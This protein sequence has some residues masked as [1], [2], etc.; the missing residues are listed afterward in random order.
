MGFF[1]R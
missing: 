1:H